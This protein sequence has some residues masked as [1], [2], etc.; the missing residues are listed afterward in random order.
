MPLVITNQGLLAGTEGLAGDNHARCLLSAH[1]D[2]D[3]KLILSTPD[4][5]P[6]GNSCNN[7]PKRRSNAVMA[8]GLFFDDTAL[9]VEQ[10]QMSK[11]SP[12]P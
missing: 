3:S 9:V 1:V 4:L 6:S 7:V 8:S 2:Y 11:K 5:H 12:D 10:N